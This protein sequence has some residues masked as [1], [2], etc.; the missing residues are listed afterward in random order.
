MKVSPLSIKK[1]EFNKTLRGYDKDEVQAFLDK[2]AGE[3]ETLQKE[4]DSLKKELEE[5]TVKL[6]E[7]RRIE[8]NLQD[9]LLKAQESSSKSIESTKKQSGL[10]IKE[11]EIKVSQILEKARENAN[12]IRN[13]VINLREEKNLIIANLKAIINSQAHLLEMKVE[14]AGEEVIETGQ[15]EQAKKIDINV[16]EIVNKLL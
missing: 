9:T 10:M 15:I 2:L 13:S 1:Q 16:E 4:N 7:F 6:T 3:F 5:S 11:A 12:E 8:K 14:T